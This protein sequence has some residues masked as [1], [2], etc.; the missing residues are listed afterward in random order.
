MKHEQVL[1]ALSTLIRRVGDIERKVVE[2][3]QDSTGSVAVGLD[4]IREGTSLLR[5]LLWSAH[6]AVDAER[7]RLQGNEGACHKQL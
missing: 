4:R 2:L 7:E 3:S 6:M 1:D 5:G